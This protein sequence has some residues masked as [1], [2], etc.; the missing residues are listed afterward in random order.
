[1]D[2]R[3]G[4]CAQCL[5]KP[6]LPVIRA[7][8]FDP[9]SPAKILGL[10]AIDAMAGFAFVQWTQ[11]EWDVPDAIIPMPD[12][13]SVAIGKTFS[14]LMDLP[15]IRA[16]ESDFTY[17]EDRL[18]EEQTLLIFD[19]ANRRERLLQASLALSESFPKITYLLS[20]HSYASYLP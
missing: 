17:K 3:G 18:E 11:L 14:R 5:Q 7:Y 19:V 4:L 9:A 1:M 8:V 10:E 6:F 2:R 15:F 12:R 16:L 20:L 13:D